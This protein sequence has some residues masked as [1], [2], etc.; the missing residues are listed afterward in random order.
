MGLDKGD[1]VGNADLRARG[2]DDAV[3]DED[4]A[5]FDDAVGQNQRPAQGVGGGR[6]RLL[7]AAGSGDR[8]DYGDQAESAA[9]HHRGTSG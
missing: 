3:A 9:K 7:A 5:G 1:M 2:D 4:D 8:E 6:G